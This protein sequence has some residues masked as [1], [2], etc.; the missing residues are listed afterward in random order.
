MPDRERARI[1]PGVRHRGRPGYG[2]PGL[3]PKRGYVPRLTRAL[4]PGCCAVAVAAAVLFPIPAAAQTEDP[5]T[6]T[7]ADA[8]NVVVNRATA[9]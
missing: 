3:R 4:H 5:T 1:A 7:T 9:R 6:C 8:L 2:R